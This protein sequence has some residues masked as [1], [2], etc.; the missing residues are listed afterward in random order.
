MKT[1]AKLIDVPLVIADA[2][3]LTQAGYV[4]EDVESILFKV[5]TCNGCGFGTLH[6]GRTPFSLTQHTSRSFPS[7]FKPNLIHLNQLY[8]ESGQDLERCQRG[9]VYI[10]EIDKIRKSGGNVSISR[11]V[12]GEGVQHAL[13]KIVEGN[14]INVPKVRH[15]LMF[16]VFCCVTIIAQNQVLMVLYYI[17][18]H[19]SLDARIRGGSSF[20]L[21]QQISY[22]LVVEP[23]LD[24]SKSSTKGWMLPLLDS[25]L[26]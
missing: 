26:Q 25:E 6:I 22:S 13:L 16:M 23:L 19:R 24:S 2:T 5:S 17:L 15:F 9:I 20:K 4:G 7:S 11:D 1:L 21:I 8:L 14:V 12:S 10:D 18:P 3:C